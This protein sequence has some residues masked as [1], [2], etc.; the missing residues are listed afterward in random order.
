MDIN[1]RYINEIADA[2]AEKHAAVMVGAGFS[3]NAEKLTVSQEKF[4]DWNE[5]TDKFY[6]KYVIQ[7]M[8]LKKN[9]IVL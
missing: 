8:K 1:E 3:K 2:L 6:E 7:G 5:L 4:L 9:I